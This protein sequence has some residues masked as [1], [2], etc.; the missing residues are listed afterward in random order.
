MT[1]NWIS[2]SL[3]EED[4]VMNRISGGVGHGSKDDQTGY[5]YA[6]NSRRD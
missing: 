5:F 1:A 6:G 2:R 4:Q 3:G